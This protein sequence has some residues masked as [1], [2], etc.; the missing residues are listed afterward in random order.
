MR[1][2]LCASTSAAITMLLAGCAHQ[3][4]QS[5]DLVRADLAIEQA[6]LQEAGQYAPAQLS[7]AQL[8]LQR[9]REAAAVGNRAAAAQL[10]EEALVAAQLAQVE[11]DR[12]RIE[13]LVEM[14]IRDSEAR[15]Q[16]Q[17]RREGLR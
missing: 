3:M 15:R 6:E 16:Q 14:V 5:M 10:A 17:A 8:K 1:V 2:S 12:A 9:A 7:E 11:A 4:P 13:Q